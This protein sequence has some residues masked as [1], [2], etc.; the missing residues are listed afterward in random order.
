MLAS[1]SYNTYRKQAIVYPLAFTK[2]KHRYT[3]VLEWPI[4]W[5]YQRPDCLVINEEARSWYLRSKP[6]A[7]DWIG[8]ELLQI[9]ANQ[10]NLDRRK[11]MRDRASFEGK[12][13]ESEFSTNKH[14][15]WCPWLLVWTSWWHIKRPNRSVLD[16]ATQ[17]RDSRWSCSSNDPE[18]TKDPVNPKVLKRQKVAFEEVSN[19]IED[20]CGRRIDGAL[21]ADKS[22][23]EKKCSLT[24]IQEE[25]WCPGAVER[26][27]WGHFLRPNSSVSDET[28]RGWLL[29]CQC[30]D[31]GQANNVPKEVQNYENYH[32]WQLLG[33][34]ST[35]TD[36]AADT[37]ENQVLPT[38]KGEDGYPA[39]VGRNQGRHL[40]GPHS[41]VPGDK[42][43]GWFA[44]YE[45]AS[46]S[47]S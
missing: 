6:S 29:G 37:E 38:T 11:T 16:V 14:R 7:L 1:L 33:S 27:L 30:A 5:Y 46:S 21:F 15:A 19:H 20:K 4:R 47:W 44:W 26:A 34:R 35:T 42:A 32:N 17:V 3:W 39:V 31:V 36:E 45:R 43:W 28:T 10:P 22:K 12:A 18:D 23:S 24:A 9:E 41:V 2:F 40:E 25:N 8:N 13:Y